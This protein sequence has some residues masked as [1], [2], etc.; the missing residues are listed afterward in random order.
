MKEI[1]QIIQKIK[2]KTKSFNPF[3]ENEISYKLIPVK[4]SKSN[5]TI[6]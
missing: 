3:L 6:K 4:I 2:E 5:K 1:I